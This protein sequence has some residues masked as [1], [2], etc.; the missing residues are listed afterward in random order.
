M[1]DMHN[2]NKLCN[3]WPNILKAVDYHILCNVV[4]LLI[5]TTFSPI[6]LQSIAHFCGAMVSPNIFSLQAIPIP[7]SRASAV[8]DIFNLAAEKLGFKFMV[9]KSK[10]VWLLLMHTQCLSKK[11]AI[12][13][14][15]LTCICLKLLK[16]FLP[17]VAHRM[18][19]K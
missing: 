19:Y 3:H 17:Y 11:L 8:Q 9:L 12:S 18:H 6:F 15:C 4:I 14:S 7:F 16:M 1:I 13:I 2:T 10:L 5:Q